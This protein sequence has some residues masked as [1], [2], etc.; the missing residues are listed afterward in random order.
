MWSDYIFR[1]LGV[2][3]PFAFGELP[4]RVDTRYSSESTES[5]S[6]QVLRT[7]LTPI[8]KLVFGVIDGSK[9]A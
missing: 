6:S 5:F 8:V 9:A 4:E 3:T 7:V 2:H 1:Q